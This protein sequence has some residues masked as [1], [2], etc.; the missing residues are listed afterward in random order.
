M[1]INSIV[2]KYLNAKL[3]LNS[4]NC[5]YKLNLLLIEKLKKK[6]EIHYKKH[7]KE[8]IKMQK[9]QENIEKINEEETYKL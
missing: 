2:L 5:I 3:V 4:K 1:Q 6:E 8:I 9:I 7:N